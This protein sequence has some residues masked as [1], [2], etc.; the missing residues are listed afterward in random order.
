MGDHSGFIN[1]FTVIYMPFKG[2]VSRKLIANFAIIL[3]HTTKIMM[4]VSE[5]A[6]YRLGP[7]QLKQNLAYCIAQC[8]I[9]SYHNAIL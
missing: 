4:K 9:N 5:G 7:V 6:F 3:T 8:S 2:G 1:S